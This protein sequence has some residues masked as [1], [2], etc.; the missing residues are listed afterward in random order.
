MSAAL[1]R[2]DSDDDDGDDDRE[3]D[4]HQGDDRKD[5]AQH[6]ADA[7][8]LFIGVLDARRLDLL[9]G[10]V[11]QVPGDRGEDRDENAEDPEDQD[12][13]SLWVLLWRCAV[14]LLAVWH[15][16]A[17]GLEL[18]GLSV[19]V[20]WARLGL[21]GLTVRAGWWARLGLR[22]VFVRI[23]HGPHCC[24]CAPPTAAGG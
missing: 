19:R 21:P 23:G 24:L 16:L 22:I 5:L 1:A 10:L 8:V 14:G 15:R 7:D 6:A 20:G 2:S 13:G 12:Q 17:A 18:P 11:A 9:L 4:G 3:R